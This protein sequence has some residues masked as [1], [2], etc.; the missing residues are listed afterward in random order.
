[1]KLNLNSWYIYLFALSLSTAAYAGDSAGPKTKC[2]PRY[3]VSSNVTIANGV[4]GDTARVITPEGKNFSVRF[5]SID[6][7]ETHYNGKSQGE[8]G[9]RAANRLQE[10]LPTGTRVQLEFG[11]QVCDP[12]GRVLA[13][14]IKDGVNINEQMVREGWAVNYCIYPN[15][16]H[17]ETLGE[18]TNQNIRDGRGFMGDS[19]MEIPYIWRR[20][21]SGRAFTSY[22]GNMET[23]EVFL[24]GHED[25][26]PVGNRMFFLKKEDIEAPYHLVE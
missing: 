2:D 22:V 23:K 20:K 3:P 25:R 9:D 26:V 6:T 8:W 13:Y 7:P 14:V 12:N 1:M 10:I 16:A 11:D 15:V 17:C 21:V 4:D 19:S 18:L 24:P 5:L